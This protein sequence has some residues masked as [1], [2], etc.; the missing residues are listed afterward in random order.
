[1]I[2]HVIQRAEAYRAMSAREI[3]VRCQIPFSEGRLL[4]GNE[5]VRLEDRR[6]PEG[7]ITGQVVHYQLVAEGDAGERWAQV[8]LAISSPPKQGV[9]LK[10]LKALKEATGIRNPRG[11]TAKDLVSSVQVF[12]GAEAQNQAIEGKSFASLA[13]V[14]HA[15]EKAGTRVK[16]ELK[17]LK[18]TAE[19]SHEWEAV[20]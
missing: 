13:A 14:Y 20:L 1:V 6:L 11:T 19:L 10:G 16:I 15:L 2:E 3:E 5:C 4:R 18:P 9:K 8:T 17:D 7:A 12:Q